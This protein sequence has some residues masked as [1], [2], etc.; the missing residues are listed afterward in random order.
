MSLAAPLQVENER[1]PETTPAAARAAVGLSGLFIRTS[2]V[3]GAEVM[4]YNLARGL[5]G[6]GVAGTFFVRRRADVDPLFL[7]VA[8]NLRPP[9]RLDV[10]ELGGPANRFIGEHV[11]VTEAARRMGLDAVLF[12]N[13]FTPPRRQPFRVVTVIHDLQYVHLPQHFSRRKRAWLRFAHRVTLRS[14]DEV[15]AISAC[16]REDIAHTYGLRRNVGLHVI[17]N[18]VDWDRFGADATE[19]AQAVTGGRPFVLSVASQ[20]PHKN[21]ETLIRAFDLARHDLRDHRLVLAGQLG[22]RLRGVVQGRDLQDLIR[23]R[24]LSNEVV[25]TGH[26]SEALLGSLYRRT[27]L[28]VLPS[29]F[30]GFG[31]PAV[32]ALG[33]GVPTL[34][35]RRTSLPEVTLGKAAYT[36]DPTSPVELAAR[37]VEMVRERSRFVPSPE[38]MASLRAHYDPRRIAREY[39]RV[40]I[41]ASPGKADDTAPGGRAGGSV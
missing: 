1:N 16:V 41:G 12:P 3:G 29:L 26:V 34:T 13:Y 39:L 10:E 15:I 11:H 35:T 19:D 14:A 22:H 30:E 8:R 37:M 27:D 4:L 2:I 20:Y 18:P 6:I 32:E 24:G 23:E 31:M 5:A 25:L 36:D 28:F 38:T 9:G 33:L 7:K 17:P 21:L 40:M